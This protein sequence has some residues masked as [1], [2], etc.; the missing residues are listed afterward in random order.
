[1][2][3]SKEVRDAVRAPRERHCISLVMVGLM[4]ADGHEISRHDFHEFLREEV[5]PMFPGFS[6]TFQDGYW[7]GKSEPA[8]TLS[9]IGPE[10]GTHETNVR[11]VAE[12][13]KTR[14]NQAAVITATM[15]ADVAMNCWPF[16]PVGAYHRAGKG[17]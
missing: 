17:Y 12:K 8:A 13:Y 9:F 11:W 4:T 3:V 2:E 10:T 5:T 7:E 14:F 6:V 15:A 1:M 16:G